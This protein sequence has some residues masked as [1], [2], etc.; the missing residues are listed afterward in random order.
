MANRIRVPK[1]MTEVVDIIRRL[2]MYIRLV[3][4]LLRDGRV[5]AQQ[6]LILV[7]IGAYLFFPIDL[8]PDFVPVLG[9]LDDL[10]VVLLGLDL[11]I[12]SAPPDI[13]EEHLAKI[14]QDKDQLRRDIA[15]AER[16]L[17]DRLGDVRATVDK[18]RTQGRKATGRKKREST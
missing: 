7:G 6:K 17:G 14:S 10:A 18:F 11:F 2:P 1:D 12:R 4:A 15:T 8:I 13:V 9:Q 16:L 5:P 3:W